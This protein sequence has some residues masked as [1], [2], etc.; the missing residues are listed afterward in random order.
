VDAVMIGPYDLSA[1]MGL[2]A[3]F[4]HPEMV[5]AVNAVLKACKRHNVVPGIHVVQ[6]NPDE[7]VSRYREG[8]RFIAYSLDIT[9][10][11]KSCING[12]AEI[13]S[14]LHEPLVEQ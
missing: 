7:A 9:M 13:K 1:S 3:Q 5:S 4:E 12:L 11:L 8:Y 14:Q 2:T 6:P 10:L